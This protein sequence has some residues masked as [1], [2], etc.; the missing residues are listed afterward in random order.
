M[1]TNT[2]SHSRDDQAG[3]QDAQ[4][5]QNDDRADRLPA[6]M[7]SSQQVL[8]FDDESD[9]PVGFSLTARAR[10]VIAPHDLPALALVPPGAGERSRDSQKPGMVGLGGR[11]QA[12]APEEGAVGRDWPVGDDPTDTRPSR[13]RALRRAGLSPAAIADQLQVDPLLIHAWIGVPVSSS[14]VA[15]QPTKVGHA[16][17]SRSPGDGAA[18]AL[19][20]ERSAAF[21]LAR[22]A[23]SDQAR[24]ALA[25]DPGFA[26]G[27]G[28]LSS[29]VEVDRHAI[30]ITTGDQDVA[31]RVLSWLEEELPVDPARVR[32]VLRLGPR[33][34]GD[35]VAHRWAARLHLERDRVATARWHDAPEPE[36]VQALLRV[37]DPGIA[38]T[39]A[40]WRD[41]LLAPVQ[42]HPADSAF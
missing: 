2:R 36:A 3:P 27:L 14:H 38:A 33:A 28:L 6:T 26:A 18:D 8:P 13:A 39:V 35:L 16:G 29:I 22:A 7:S 40:G 31:A 12:S 23:A 30:T 21:L 42:L 4:R 9:E 10:R 17:V 34:A 11:C 32:L 37:A 1:D 25:H 20:E 15:A 5:A 24:P 41:A 19:A